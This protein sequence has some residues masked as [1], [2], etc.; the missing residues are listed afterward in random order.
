MNRKHIKALTGVR[1]L[2]ALWVLFHHLVSQYPLSGVLPEW[3]EHVAKKG[4]LGVDLFFLLSGFVISYVHQNDFKERITSGELKRFAVLRFARVYPVHFVTTVALIPIYLIG[5]NFF[6]Y[7][8][9]A[10]A[11][12]L[13][14]LF[15]SLSLTNGL[16][17]TDSVGWNSPSWSVGSEVFV[18]LL[19]PFLTY[20]IFAK[21]M[22]TLAC[23]AGCIAILMIT[24]SIGW[25][26]SDGERYFASWEANIL[27][28][29]SEFM[30]GC[31]L[32]NICKN[33]EKQSFW[34]LADIAFISILLLVIFKVPG[35]WDV[36]FIIAFAALV[37][38]LFE[39]K[40]AVASQLGNRVWIYLGEISYSVYLCHAVIF[41]V[42]NSLFQKVFS[43][44]IGLHIVAAS[45]LYVAATWL[46]SHFM[47]YHL[48]IK[49]RDRIKKAF[50][51]K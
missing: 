50:L 7:Q 19:F 22:S 14:K 26:F 45:L 27:R 11:F 16:G 48:E 46:V 12:T 29:T 40:G 36:L 5:S 33:N 34:W 44:D 25:H 51:K 15:Y 8:S 20:F 39:D 43:T 23:L 17:I 9:P 37:Y 47:Y 10:D 13:S 31:F 38:G 18:Y 28:V 3:A 4:W 42:L 30:I 41:M 49:A 24:T 21:K 1:G 6:S 2:A 32:F 35:Q